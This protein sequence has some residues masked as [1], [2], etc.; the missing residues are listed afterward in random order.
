MTKRSWDSIHTHKVPTAA[1]LTFQPSLSVTTRELITG[2]RYFSHKYNVLTLL[3]SRICI[4]PAT[5]FDK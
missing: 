1:K 3:S 5:G 4:L 2:A